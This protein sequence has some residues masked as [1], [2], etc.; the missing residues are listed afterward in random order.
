MA[1]ITAPSSRPYFL[2]Q[3]ETSLRASVASGEPSRHR[4]EPRRILS[5][6]PGEIIHTHVILEW[7]FTPADFFGE[8][9]TATRDGYALYLADGSA[10]A[11]IDGAR[12]AA[13]KGMR[14]QVHREL[15]GR[16]AAAQ[17]LRHQP[18][19]L[20][21]PKTVKVRPDGIRD[22]FIEVQ[23]L[24]CTITGG[25]V[26]VSITDPSGNVVYDSEQVRLDEAKAFMDRVARHTA[27][28][29]LDALLH[30]YEAAVRD[31]D[32]EL[33]HLYELRDALAAHF[34]GDRE[35]RTAL[36]VSANEW[37]RFGQL[38]N[39]G[40]LRQGRHRGNSAGA[41][42]DATESELGEARAFAKKM[43][44]GYLE[45]LDGPTR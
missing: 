36:G 41:L 39:A 23:G 22:I 7:R 18:Y 10:E 45:I 33:I 24:A 29:L 21:G 9:V 4:S 40:P 32:N 26:G 35:A 5:A 43:L 11:Q 3:C 2:S 16:F 19:E 6:M 37:S 27:D 13:H 15:A 12:F 30:S 44:T 20:S 14:D 25:T 31:P 1:G 34:G 38:C 42:R 8:P 28:T 17:L